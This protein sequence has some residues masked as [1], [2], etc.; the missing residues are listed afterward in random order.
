MS[1]TWS[2]STVSTLNVN[3]PDFRFSN[4]SRILLLC[5][6][7]IY[8]NKSKLAWLFIHA[9]AILFLLWQPEQVREHHSSVLHHACMSNWVEYFFL[10]VWHQHTW[11]MNM[12]LELFFLMRYEE[13]GI[14]NPGPLTPSLWSYSVLFREKKAEH[15]HAEFVK[16][17]TTARR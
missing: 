16:N 13:K 12:C 14:I 1:A 17:W 9:N 6:E 4:V 2:V 3:T 5:I 10:M 7:T 8:T 15:K 11:G